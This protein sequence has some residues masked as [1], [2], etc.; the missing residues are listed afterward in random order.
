MC[1][2]PVLVTIDFTKT[3]IVDYD[4]LGHGISAILMQ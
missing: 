4:A 3:F 1:I 2:T